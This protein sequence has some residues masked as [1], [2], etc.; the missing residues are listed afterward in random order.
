MR[1]VFM[2]SADLSCPSLDV[3]LQSGRQVVGV[4][5]QPDRPKGRNLKLTPSP[6]RVLAASKGIP[7][8]TPEKINTAASIADIISMAPDLIVVVAYGQILRKDILQ[9]P[10]KGCINMHTSLLPKY[11]GAAPIQWAIAN[12]DR[13]TGVTSMFMNEKMDAG[14]IIYQREVAINSDETGGSLHD[15]LAVAAASLLNETVENMYSGD[16]PRHSQ[17]ES[18]A[19]FASKLHKKDGKIDW[20]L[21]S[22]KI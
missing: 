6:V 4:V 7:V 12:G 16:V 17:N 8:L 1:I 18:E 14:D 15:K 19:T 2:G 22:G 3:L 9:M 20:T 5:T 10:R 11:R 13:L 21:T